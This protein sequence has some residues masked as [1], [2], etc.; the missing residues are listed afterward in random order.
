MHDEAEIN[1]RQQQTIYKRLPVHYTVSAISLPQKA[2]IWLSRIQNVPNGK[3]EGEDSHDPS[4]W[5]IVGEQP[6]CY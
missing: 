1:P 3:E 4:V 5:H 2:I 6:L